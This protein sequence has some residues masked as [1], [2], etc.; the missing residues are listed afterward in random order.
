LMM[1]F[2]I[3]D[4]PTLQAP[5]LVHARTHNNQMA[6]V[7]RGSSGWSNSEVCQ[8]SGRITIQQSLSSSKPTSASKHKVKQKL[9]VFLSIYDESLKFFWKT[10]VLLYSFD[11]STWT[12]KRLKLRLS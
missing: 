6:A 7:R 12:E 2:I 8:I 4:G 10:F 9:R 5:S 11:F 3:N 1:V